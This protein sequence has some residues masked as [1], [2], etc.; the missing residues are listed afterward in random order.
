MVEIWNR[1]VHF[2]SGNYESF[3]SQ[4]QE[5]TEQLEAAYRNQRERIEQLEAFI[6]RFRYQA[7]KAKQ[8]QSRIKELEKIE[9]IDFRHEEKTIHFPFRSPSRAA[10]LWPSSRRCRKATATSL[11]SAASTLS[12]SAATGLLWSASTGLGSRR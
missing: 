2:Y 3:S 8:V 4:K 10:A 7:T 11:S 9:R 12:S 1:G 5:R 6:S